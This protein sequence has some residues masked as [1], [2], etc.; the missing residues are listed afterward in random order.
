M[1]ALSVG[2]AARAAVFFA[3][4]VTI[5]PPDFLHYELVLFV[6]E[7]AYLVFNESEQEAHACILVA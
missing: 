6:F 1:V 5:L 4:L 7:D 2:A 3:F